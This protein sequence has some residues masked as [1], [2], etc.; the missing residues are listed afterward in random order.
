LPSRNPSALREKAEVLFDVVSRPAPLI[1][2]CN[3]RLLV[4]SVA[5]DV[6]TLLD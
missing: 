5:G 6:T 3:V 4:L 2:D 1:D